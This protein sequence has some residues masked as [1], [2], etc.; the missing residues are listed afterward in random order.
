[1]AGPFAT[2]TIDRSGTIATG[3][4]SQLLM[5]ANPQRSYLFVQNLSTGD[6]WINFGTAAVASQPSIRIPANPASFVME[7]SYV[8]KE[9]VNIIGATSAAAFVAKEA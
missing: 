6:L 2:T 8:S 5:P 4:A 1:M 7:A 9:A 3:G